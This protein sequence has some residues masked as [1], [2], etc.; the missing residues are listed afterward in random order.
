MRF[1][2]PSGRDAFECQ[3]SAGQQ[4]VQVAKVDLLANRTGNRVLCHIQGASEH[5]RSLEPR[6]RHRHGGAEAGR[7]ERVSGPGFGTS[8][9]RRRTPGPLALYTINLSKTPGNSERFSLWL[10]YWL[11]YASRVRRFASADE[12]RFTATEA[13][14][15]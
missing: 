10:R 14:L 15:R 2:A 8:R 12:Q 7:Q 13:G 4:D 6:N 5:A 1:L 9:D 3:V 11:P